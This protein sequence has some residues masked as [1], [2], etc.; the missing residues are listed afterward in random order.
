[1]G[2][3]RGWDNDQR[4]RLHLA[5]ATGFLWGLVIL[6]S[7]AAPGDEWFTEEAEAVGIDF[8]HFN[9]M[10]G[11]F[12]ISEILAPGAAMFDMDADGDLDIYL[13]QGQM[14]GPGKTLDQALLPPRAP[15]PGR[16]ASIF[17]SRFTSS[18]SA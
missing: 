5:V 9:G 4:V 11:A 3:S 18:A 16:G 10:S 8:V 2:Q 12:F 17:M 7:S 15:L 13:V 1:M 6:G 14:L